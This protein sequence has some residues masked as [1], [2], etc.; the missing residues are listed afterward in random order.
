MP[1]KVTCFTLLIVPLVII[2]CTRPF[3]TAD[4]V[5]SLDVDQLRSRLNN[6][7][8]EILDVRYGKTWT[9]SDEK[10]QGARRTDPTAFS[11][12]ADTLPGDKDLVLY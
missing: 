7:D 10:I 6:P 8:T 12:W 4:Q 5:K 3:F 9:E 11:T 2:G 1:A